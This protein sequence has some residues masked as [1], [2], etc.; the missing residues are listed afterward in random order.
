MKKALKILGWL[1]ILAIG[2]G[3]TVYLLAW[4]SP[5]YFIAKKHSNSIYL[6]FK[7]Y[8]ADHKK[9]YIVEQKNLVIFGA[10]HTRNR[11]DV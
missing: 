5:D 8:K 2:V 11:K 6:P 9:P 7:N 1:M 10:E 3:G 4:K